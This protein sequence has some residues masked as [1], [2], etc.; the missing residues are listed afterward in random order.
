LKSRR[1]EKAM[2]TTEEIM[3]SIILGGIATLGV[4]FCYGGFAAKRTVY[5]IL[6]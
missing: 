5:K 2:F 4:M 6:F 1:K 3:K